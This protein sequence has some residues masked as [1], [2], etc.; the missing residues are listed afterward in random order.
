MR[1]L[2]PAFIDKE[3]EPEQYCAVE[4][5]DEVLS[6]AEK[7]GVRN[8][9]LTGA[10]GSGKSS[11]IRTLIRDFPERRYFLDISLATLRSNFD[12]T[13]NG[14]TTHEKKS[15]R[16]PEDDLNHRIEF[17]ILQQLAYK[18]R[19]TTLPSS[20]FKRIVNFSNNQLIRYGIAAVFFIVAFLI[21]FEP[22]FARVDSL[23]NAF[24]W[25]PGWNLGFDI[26]AALYLL[27]CIVM[28]VGSVVRVYSNSRLKKVKIM[29]GEVEMNDGEDSS[30]IN[31]HIDEIIYFFSQTSYNIVF[32]EDLDR[33]NS[34]YIFLKLRE[35]NKI[36]NSSKEILKK[37]TR[38]FPKW[39]VWKYWKF[40]KTKP[41]R[42]HIVFVYAVKDDIFVN[43]DRTKFFDQIVTV[44]PVINPSNSRDKLKQ[45]LKEN[46]LVDGVIPDEDIRQLAFFIQDMRLLINI[47]NEFIQYKERLTKKNFSLNLT[48]L[49]AIIIYKNIFPQDFTALHHKDGMIFRIFD[50]KRNLIELTVEDLRKKREETEA[51]KEEAKK[52]RHLQIKDLRLLFIY[53]I[54]KHLDY[55]VAYELKL[56]NGFNSL[57]K[58]AASDELFEELL[59]KSWIEYKINGRGGGTD[60]TSVNVRKLYEE[61]GFKNKIALQQ[62]TD[63]RYESEIFRLEREI[64]EAFKWPMSRLL[65]LPELR[66]EFDNLKINKILEIMILEGYIAE[67]YYDY[68]S[69]FHEGLLSPSDRAYILE[70]R[71]RGKPQI[72]RHID[73]IE[74][75]VNELSPADFDSES[76]LNVELV[77]FLH[78]HRRNDTLPMR[79]AYNAVTSKI[80]LSSF[81]YDFLTAY[82]RQGANHKDVFDDCLRA[83]FPENRLKILE[84]IQELRKE[85]AE[86]MIHAI[87]NYV[88]FDLHPELSEWAEDNFSFFK[89]RF[90]DL[91]EQRL[92]N[93]LDY[94]K[95]NNIDAQDE[96]LLDLV[97][98]KNAYKVNAHNILQLLKRTP[99]HEHIDRLDVSLDMIRMGVDAK[100]VKWILGNDENLKRILIELPLAGKQESQ[101]SIDL[102]L[103]SGLD[104]KVKTDFLT[105]QQ[106]KRLNLDGLSEHEAKVLVNNNLLIPTWMNVNELYSILPE[107]KTPL[108]SYIKEN[109]KSLAT[110]EGAKGLKNEDSLFVLLLGD[111]STLPLQAY[112]DLATAFDWEFNNDSRILTLEK[113]RFQILLD[114]DRISYSD[115]N[116]ELLKGSDFCESYFLYYHDLFMEYP[117]DAAKLSATKLAAILGNDLFTDEKVVKALSAVPFSTITS[118]AR[119]STLLSKALVAKE[120]DDSY[121]TAELRELMTKNEDINSNV[122]L[123]LR[124]LPSVT[125]SDEIKAVLA[126]IG[127]EGYAKLSRQEGKPK[128]PATEDVESLLKF[129][130]SRGF[131]SSYSPESKSFRIH[132]HRPQSDNQ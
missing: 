25:G 71:Q 94:V 122:I 16:E 131:I 82:W 96:G 15:P 57:D 58:V 12:S 123:A 39:Q 89:A 6:N 66:S 113:E 42:R 55:R 79:D 3:K 7:E 44:I 45:L 23:Y 54:I 130:R 64:N 36:L 70:I 120:S 47:V 84:E 78:K 102:V 90:S 121:T 4:S 35:L 72:D 83:Y 50:N 20:R 101:E 77:D 60:S 67:D 24:S 124:V 75:F 2:L 91:D 63:Y 98:E 93:L 49:L 99:E 115:E 5:L 28:V 119:L 86:N 108:V 126:S 32:F 110:K 132:F 62:E 87:I 53:E 114:N 74:N 52:T 61:T 48:K 9:A 68:I 27:F 85:D 13:D 22:A 104:E 43:E 100:A 65:G 103:K 46:G 125:S 88:S 17:S 118:N 31:K 26:I 34:P 127:G 38:N 8:V 81:K 30:I 106:N 29:D 111:N 51:K 40:Y 109:V 18:E 80:T 1:T 10:Y 69:Y 19:S 112:K 14:Q 73:H 56:E 97:V 117:E 76:A 116:I 59:T 33:F 129:L 92:G 11:I 128:L 41:E 105:G 107:D 95:F 37:K 21:L